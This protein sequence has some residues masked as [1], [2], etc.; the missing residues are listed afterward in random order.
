MATKIQGMTKTTGAF[1]TV[2]YSYKG[3]IIKKSSARYMTGMYD[4]TFQDV[5]IMASSL[6]DAAKQIDAIVA[7]VAA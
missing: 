7:K 1:N 5:R 2:Q 4:F 3:A 6:T